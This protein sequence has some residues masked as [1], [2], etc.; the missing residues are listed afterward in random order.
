MKKMRLV[1]SILSVILLLSETAVFAGGPPQGMKMPT[2]HVDV[3][4]V[5][6]PQKLKIDNL[7]Y[8]AETKAY[9][10]VTVVAKVNGTLEKIFFKEG[11]VVKK[12]ET[13]FKIDDSIY[14]A[15]LDSAKA[16]LHMAQATF[17]KA[18][19]DWERTEKLYKR[20]SISDREKDAYFSAYKKALAGVEAAKANLELAQINYDYTDVVS[21][22]GGIT[23]IKKIDVGNY[24]TAGTPLVDIY[25]IDRVYVYF[26]MPK[27]DFEKLGNLYEIDGKLKID[28]LKKGKI[29]AAG[30]VDYQDKKIEKSTSTVRLRAVVDNAQKKILPGDFVKVRLSNVYLERA[31]LIP[32]KAL[33]Q[34]QKGTIVFVAKNSHVGVSPIFSF[35][36]YKDKY[37]VQGMI[38]PGDKVIVNNFFRIKP[39]AEI[40]VDKIVNRQGK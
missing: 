34:S 6:P 35:S 17:Y 33:L 7:V 19:K 31:L 15:H 28:I 25:D 32:Q 4:E 10:Y 26:S 5:Q 23:T 30:V 2:P 39:G 14:K 12:D 16:N 21:P 11:D 24:V 1:S 8:P 13:L 3:F 37:V 29:V 18:K 27:S 9:S 40:V 22:I 36:E 20:H 38:K